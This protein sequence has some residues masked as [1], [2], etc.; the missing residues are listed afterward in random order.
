MQQLLLIGIFEAL[1]FAILLF[2]KKNRCI[3]DGI[4]SLFFFIVSVSMF[5]V[6]MDGYN[7]SHHFRYPF[8]LFTAAPLILLHGPLL[9]FYIKTLT[10]Q[11]FHVS[12]KHLVHLTPFLLML[13]QHTLYFYVLSPQQKISVAIDESFKSDITYPVFMF[14]VV[15]SPLFYFI[16][17]IRLIKRYDHQLKNYFSRMNDINLNWLR[18]LLLASIVFYFIVGGIFLL[19]TLMPFIS[20]SK[21][22]MICFSFSTIYI[23]FLGFYGHKQI[24]L[25]ATYNLPVPL[26]K[27]E[28]TS[29]P[30]ELQTADEQFINDLLEVMKNEKPYLNPDLNLPTLSAILKITPEY[31]SSVLNNLLNLNFYDFINSYRVNEFKTV[32]LSPDN[33]NYTIIAIAY[34]CGFNSKATFNRVFKNLTGVTPS[35]YMQQSQ[36][37]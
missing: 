9:W 21:L 32:C 24:N 30:N 3:S 34:S 17:G 5:L 29:V 6:Y 10:Q 13:I 33:K 19:N 20:F 16:W 23:L 4:L 15:L 36:Q 8:L 2:L 25:F 1:S 18:I 31:L 35:E 11:P 27:E 14:L 28:I 22:Q 37:K 7:R 26:D 12:P